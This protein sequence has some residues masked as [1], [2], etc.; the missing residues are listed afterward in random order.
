M[1]HTYR[2]TDILKSRT[3]AVKTQHTVCEWYWYSNSYCT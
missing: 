2:Q 1:M 3:N